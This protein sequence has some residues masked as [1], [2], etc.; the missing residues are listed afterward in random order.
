MK[1]GSDSVQP[2]PRSVADLAAGLI[3][4]EAG[5]W[6][7]ACAVRWAKDHPEL[8]GP[9]LLDEALRN[10]LSAHSAPLR[11]AAVAALAAHL[12][13]AE[14]APVLHV[15]ETDPAKSVRRTVAALQAGGKIARATA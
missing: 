12:T 15:L 9:A 8:I 13:P 2:D 7:A 5:S 10:A 11:E 4:G 1:R 6:V 3:G 14:A